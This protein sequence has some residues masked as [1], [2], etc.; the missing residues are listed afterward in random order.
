MYYL[1]LMS[2]TSVDG[3]DAA[4]VDLNDRHSLV[5]AAHNTPYSESLRQSVEDASRQTGLQRRQVGA[6]DAELGQAFAQAALSL[7]ETSGIDRKLITAIGSHGQTV[8]H[9]P[10]A[11][12]PYSLQLARGDIIAKHTGITTVCDFRTADIEAGGQ[13]APMVPA[14]HAWLAQD[15]NQPVTFVNI[16]GIANITAIDEAGVVVC[17]FDTGP[18]NTLMDRWIE[19]HLHKPFDRKGDWAASAQ[20]SA[21]LLATLLDDPYFAQTGPKSTGREDFNLEWL[22]QKLAIFGKP[23]TPNTVQASLLALTTQSIRQSLLSLSPRPTTVYVCGGGAHNQALMAQLQTGLAGI[24]L[25][26]T[27]AL[28]LDPDWVEA[29]AFAWLARETLAG[30]PGNVPAVTGA[31]RPVVLGKIYTDKG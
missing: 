13:G 18:G 26:T 30:R 8:H 6:L 23:L 5:V 24:A 11:A 7:I 9:A 31:S 28:G 29:T 21:E 25:Q 16:G 3:I 4:I 14:F 17:G 2:G 27:Q 20:S 22:E 10:N 1:G 19:K 15:L 12:T